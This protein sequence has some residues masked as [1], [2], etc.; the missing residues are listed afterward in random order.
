MISQPHKSQSNGYGCPLSSQ[1]EKLLLKQQV[2]KEIPHKTLKGQV[3]LLLLALLKKD[4]KIMRIM[5]GE[6]SYI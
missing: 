1:K 4:H 2:M 3:D 6:A 5:G